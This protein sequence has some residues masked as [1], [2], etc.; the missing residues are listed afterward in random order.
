[1]KRVMGFLSTLV[2]IIIVFIVGALAAQSG[3][4][5]NLLGSQ[6]PTLNVTTVLNQIQLVSEL[7]TTRYETSGTVTIERD[8]PALIRALYGDRLILFGA[9]TVTAGIDLA[10]LSAERIT[11]N[12]DGSLTVNLPYPQLMDCILKENETRVL[13]REVSLFTWED[14]EFETIARR[15]LVLYFRNIAL[16]NGVYEMA[17]GQAETVVRAFI[18]A[19]QPDTPLTITFD[20]PP[21]QSFIPRS[22]Q[23]GSVPTATPTPAP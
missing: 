19:I 3:L 4:L 2:I 14:R 7:T 22:C 18:G 20:D 16:E 5:N 8:M 1:M 23:D 12:E 21:A 10:H 17:K 6:K 11:Q 13:A 15:N 9:G